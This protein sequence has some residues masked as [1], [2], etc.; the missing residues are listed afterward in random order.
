MKT[1]YEQ[2]QED[3][4][5]AIRKM[6]PEERKKLAASMIQPFRCG[7]TEYINGERHYRSGGWLIPQSVLDKSCAEHNDDPWPGIRAYQA[8]H[9]P[10][11]P[12]ARGRG[13]AVVG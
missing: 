9:E 4:R 13:R 10:Y 11:T 7:G 8:T 6:T 1:P 2:T 12:G 5:E 3:F